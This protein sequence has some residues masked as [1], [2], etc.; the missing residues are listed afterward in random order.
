MAG[1][2]NLIDRIKKD[3]SEI[4]SRLDT[5][6]PGLPSTLMLELTNA[7]NLKCIMCRNSTMKRKRGFMPLDMVKKALAEAKTLGMEKV[8]LYTTGESLLHPSFTEIVKMC[9]SDGFYCYLTSNG[10]PLDENMW[11]ELV[12]G[13][14]DS[15]KI[16][17]DGASREEY[18]KIRIGGNFEKLM[19]NLT[20]LKQVRDRYGS[21]PSIYAG[22]VITKLNEK[23]I[24]KF[25]NVFGPYVDGIYL[26]PI[27]NQ[28]GQITE[29]YDD[30]KPSS[31]NITS[32]WKP[33]KMLW[34]RIV[35]SYEGYIT[36]C[37][38]DYELDLVY[39]DF[40]KTTM[41]KAW[42]SPQM[43]KWREMH[44]KG[45]VTNMPLC[46]TCNAPYIQQVEVL[47]RINS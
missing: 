19:N 5:S 3:W 28:S 41:K 9:K 25:R 30:L 16:S 42:N 35:I 10:L 26:S 6:S 12:T 17:V 7:C 45:N 4:E 31:F 38:V 32:K 18:E 21:A 1:E 40:N 8:A 14:L 44:L 29:K 20:M 11:E 13:G 39:G 37:C 15:I 36:A 22:A 2:S 46:R 33:C 47:N 23:S 24:H 34:D 43:R 27:V